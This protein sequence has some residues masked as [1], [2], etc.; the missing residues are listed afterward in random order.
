MI[1]K[2]D[3]KVMNEIYGTLSDDGIWGSFHTLLDLEEVEAFY[4]DDV[5]YSA[6]DAILK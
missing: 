6:K 2:D 4:F 1:Q 5:K 3:K